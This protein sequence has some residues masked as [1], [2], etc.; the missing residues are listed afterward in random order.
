MIC[1]FDCETVP[2]VALV[3]SYYNL[4]GSDKEVSQKAFQ[5]Q[6]E[7]T[8][9]SFLPLPCHKVISICAVITDDYGVFEKV[10]CIDGDNEKDLVENFLN[11]I[12]KKN[13]KL[14]TF[15]GRGF[16]IPLLLLRAMKYSLC[17]PAYF[18]TDN[19]VLNKTKWDNYRYRFSDR[20]HVDLMDHISEFGAVRGLNL[21]L[22]CSMMGIAGKFDISGD[23]VF[24]LYYDDGVDKIKEYCQS[25]VLNTYWLYLK[26]ELLKGNLL[27]SDYL[28]TLLKFKQM[29]PQNKSYSKIFIN[30]IEKELVIHDSD[31]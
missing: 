26:Y 11:F 15:N 2:D 24:E 12:N 20:F 9:S 7:K 29:L 28:N 22:L 27:K 4:E 18:E 8:S 21:D 17:V 16:D 31:S 13:P 10:S 14:V 3:R 25:D 30:A 6:K 1:I 5:L 19:R 23:K